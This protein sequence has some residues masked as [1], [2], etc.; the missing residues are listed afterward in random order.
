[1]VDCPCE[2]W[3]KA[4][5]TGTSP[6]AWCSMMQDVL[7]VL[8]PKIEMDKVLGLPADAPLSDVCEELKFLARCSD[9]GGSLFERSENHGSR[10]D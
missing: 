2:A 3:S 9:L 4:A 7:Y 10:G 1:M 8:L 6:T 5:G